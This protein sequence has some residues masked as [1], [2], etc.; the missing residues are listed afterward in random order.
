[1]IKHDQKQ[2]G[3]KGFILY[4]SDNSALPKEVGARTQGHGGVLLTTHY[5]L[6]QPSF[7]IEART[8]SPQQAGPSHSNEENELQASPGP[9]W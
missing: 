1:M 4:L 7:L 8:N 2:L 6:A 9:I 5:W 3:E